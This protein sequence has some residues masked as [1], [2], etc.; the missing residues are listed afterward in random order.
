MKLVLL[1]TLVVLIVSI[2][3]MVTLTIS[4]MSTRPSLAT[5]STATVSSVVLKIPPFWPLDH[6]VWFAQV[7]A[8]FSTRGISVQKTKF[9]HVVASKIRNGGTQSHS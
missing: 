8:Q 5:P 1:T 9:N 2:P 6:E 7:K 3:T 4:T